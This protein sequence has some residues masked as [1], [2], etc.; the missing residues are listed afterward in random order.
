MVGCGTTGVNDA[1]VLTRCHSLTVTETSTKMHRLQSS[2]ALANDALLCW[3]SIDVSPTT[4]GMLRH[5]RRARS[6]CL[7]NDGLSASDIQRFGEEITLTVLT[8]ERSEQG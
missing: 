5:Q 3:K 6:V 1:N 7:G 4:E 2:S 8:V